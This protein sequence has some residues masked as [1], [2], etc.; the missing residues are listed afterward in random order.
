[1][2]QDASTYPAKPQFARKVPAPKVNCEKAAILMH[3]LAMLK[4]WR[5]TD[6][7]LPWL[8]HMLICIEE[9]SNVNGLRAP[10]VSMNS[11]IEGKLQ[12]S[13]I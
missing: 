5:S 4:V 13:S 3:I 8:R 10:Y 12:T 11:P 2:A 9:R 6:P 7:L 1:M